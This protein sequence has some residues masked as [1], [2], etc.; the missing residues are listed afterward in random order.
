M[1]RDAYR[2]GDAESLADHITASS[3]LGAGDLD[4]L[5][6]SDLNAFYSGENNWR[7]AL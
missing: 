4:R 2:G 3:W 7:I 6:I 5:N 1:D